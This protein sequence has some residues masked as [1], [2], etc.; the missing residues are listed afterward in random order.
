MWFI[1]DIVYILTMQ[2]R[3]HEM[4]HTVRMSDDTHAIFGTQ[5][6]LRFTR[7]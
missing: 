2:R 1:D 6:G 7:E 3:Q 4:H 5:M